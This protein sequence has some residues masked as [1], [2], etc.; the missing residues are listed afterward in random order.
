[1]ETVE[2]RPVAPELLIT[3]DIH[4]NFFIGV[5]GVLDIEAIEAGTHVKNF[6]GLDGNVTGLATCTT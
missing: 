1:M 3:E 5:S 4:T 2:C 6:T